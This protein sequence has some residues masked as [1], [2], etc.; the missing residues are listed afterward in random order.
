MKK[1]FIAAIAALALVCTS[2]V[3]ASR[4]QMIDDEETSG[5]SIEATTDSVDTPTDNVETET[6]TE[7]AE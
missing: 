7:N 5:E 3:F 2:N 1:L 4:N 6:V